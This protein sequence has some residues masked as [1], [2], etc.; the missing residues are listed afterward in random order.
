MNISDMIALVRKDLHDQDSQN[1]RWTDAELTRHINRT[2]VEL[3]EMIPLPAKATLPTVADSR[4]VDISSL[5]DRV[6]VQAVEYP[7]GESPPVYQQ[8]SVWG[9]TLSIVSGSEP[10]GTN[11]HV[12][13]GVLHTLDAD[14]STVPAICEELVAAGAC[15]YAAVEW[16][17][18][19]VNRVNVGGADTAR[20]FLDW[21]NQK[22]KYFRH[23]L[24]RLGRKNRIRVS[25]LY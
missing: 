10:D 18:Y 7:V 20:E 8:F 17:V 13:Y 11:C 19:A 3:S 15:G 14:G 6:M 24:T 9:D 12:Y 5:T 22:L 25:S 21:G 16:A 2:V 4:E 1:Y 23:E